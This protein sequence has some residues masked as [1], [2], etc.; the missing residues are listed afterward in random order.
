[1]RAQRHSAS[2]AQ[3]E[4]AGEDLAGLLEP[5]DVVLL[6]GPLGA[7]KTTF[8][9]GVAR[10]L[11]V[12]ERVTSPT[13]TIVRPHECHNERGVAVLY[14]A[15]LYRVASIDEVAD[16]ALGE[17]VEESALALIEWGERGAALWGPEHWEV[18][19]TLDDEVREL[20]LVAPPG[21]A[22]VGGWAA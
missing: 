12:L 17:L 8:A 7:G 2:P 14:H 19:F 5:G 9:K 20:A 11:G 3:T 13:F 6:S 18:R 1:M 4:S 15:D 22:P 21:R 16:L 10:G